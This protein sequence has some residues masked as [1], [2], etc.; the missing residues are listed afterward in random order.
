MRNFPDVNHVRSVN[1]EI[2]RRDGVWPEKAVK[3][4]RQLELE[5]RILAHPTPVDPRSHVICKV[6][7]CSVLPLMSWGNN[8][9]RKKRANQPVMGIGIVV[10]GGFQSKR[11][12]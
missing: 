3:N 1:L 12:P 6:S 5:K 9:Q 11:K 10:P 2:K 8:R 7:H 4:G